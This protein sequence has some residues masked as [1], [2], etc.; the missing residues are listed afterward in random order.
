MSLTRL[1]LRMSLTFLFTS[2][3]TPEEAAEARLA[4]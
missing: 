3:D 1:L 4:R 2:E